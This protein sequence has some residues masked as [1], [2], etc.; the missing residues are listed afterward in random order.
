MKIIVDPVFLPEEYR[1]QLEA[2]GDL[3]VYDK[4]PS[5]PHEFAEK[6]KDAEIIS[7]THAFVG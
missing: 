1:R 3:K 2:L 4:I 6:V 7:K 5:S